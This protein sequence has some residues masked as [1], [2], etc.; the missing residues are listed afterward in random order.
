MQHFPI[1]LSKYL[2]GMPEVI[3]LDV[4]AQTAKLATT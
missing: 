2:Q 4:Y 1:S 3:R